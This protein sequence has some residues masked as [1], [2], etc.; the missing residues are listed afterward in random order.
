MDI[1]QK[2]II[3]THSNSRALCNVPRNLTDDMY[4]SICKSGGT[5]G[6]NLCNEFLGQNPDIDTICD[7][8]LHFMD[9]AGSDE[10]VSLGSDFDGCPRIP[11]G[12]EGVQDYPKLAERLLQRGLVEQSVRKVFW[13]NALGVMSKCSM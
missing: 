11:K 12:I 4:L 1:T 6:I 9:I 5:A 3:A 7:H 13:D 2:P 10:H 8:I